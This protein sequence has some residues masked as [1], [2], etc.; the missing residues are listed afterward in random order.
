MLDDVIIPSY[1]GSSTTAQIHEAVQG[2]RATSKWIQALTGFHW[3]VMGH[4][5]SDL[6]SLDSVSDSAW[7]ARASDLAAETSCGNIILLPLWFLRVGFLSDPTCLLEPWRRFWTHLVGHPGPYQ[8]NQ[9][10]SEGGQWKVHSQQF[11]YHWNC[12]Y[13]PTGSPFI[14]R[15]N[16]EMSVQEM[17]VVVSIIRMYKYKSPYMT[18]L[19][20]S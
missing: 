1:Q 20:P 10:G 3:W 5:A 16:Q 17:N 13:K 12:P 8:N 4:L 15:M 19:R 14:G 7:S 6:V 18:L 11:K 2:F 9:L